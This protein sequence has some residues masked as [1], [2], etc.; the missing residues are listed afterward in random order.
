MRTKLGKRIACLEAENVK[1]E[2]I[3]K[4]VIS[5]NQKLDDEFKNL[6]ESLKNASNIK[7]DIRAIEDVVPVAMP[8]LAIHEIIYCDS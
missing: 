1:I 8:T 3:Q 5:L 6:E 2:D 7:I 4:E